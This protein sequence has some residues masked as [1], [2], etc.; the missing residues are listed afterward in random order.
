MARFA[1]GKGFAAGLLWARFA[2]IF[3]AKGAF[4]R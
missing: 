1:E 4:L 3:A 2:M